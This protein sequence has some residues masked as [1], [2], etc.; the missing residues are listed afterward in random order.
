MQIRWA[1]LGLASLFIAVACR[2]L[3]VAG[4]F[5]GPTAWYQGHAIWHLLTAAALGCMFLYYRSEDR[6]A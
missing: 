2:E 5:S 6:Q 1:S 4:R 3:D